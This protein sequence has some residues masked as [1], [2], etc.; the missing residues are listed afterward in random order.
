MGLAVCERG[1]VMK[2]ISEEDFQFLK[3]GCEH[4]MN[5][6]MNYAKPFVSD[7]EDWHSV[8]SDADLMLRVLEKVEIEVE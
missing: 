1:G 4:I 2:E 6:A 8:H 5:I 7:M 3:N